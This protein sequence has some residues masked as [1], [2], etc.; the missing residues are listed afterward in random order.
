MTA[1]RA[2]NRRDARH[3]AKELSRLETGHGLE[4]DAETGEIE[5]AQENR[6]ARRRQARLEQKTQTMT[7]VAYA[8]YL[9]RQKARQ[10]RLD[11]VV[12][13]EIAKADREI[14]GATP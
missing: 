11:A 6:A 7:R 9:E 4:L 14:A 8:A 2:Q 5:S 13:R 10:A 3:A 12:D 1:L